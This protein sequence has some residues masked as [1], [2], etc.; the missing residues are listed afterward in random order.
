MARSMMN[1]RNIYQT[2]WV[3]ATDTVVH[4]LIKAHLRPNSDKIPYEL[5]FGR[6]A[7]IKK[8]KVFG[9]KCHIKNNDEHL[10]KCDDRAD[11]GILLG[12][13]AQIG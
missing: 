13:A 1:E 12:Y 4:I 11:E 2:Y 5:L 7:S 9:S 8:F 3:E 6:P 10:R